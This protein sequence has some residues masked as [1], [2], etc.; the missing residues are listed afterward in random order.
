MDEITNRR[1][2]TVGG[3]VTGIAFI[4]IINVIWNSELTFLFSFLIISIIGLPLL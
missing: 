3:I 4:I 1:I 2:I